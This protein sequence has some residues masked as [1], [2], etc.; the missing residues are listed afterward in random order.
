SD[1]SDDCVAGSLVGSASASV[2]GANG[3]DYI[4]SPALSV[5]A[6][7]TYHWT[8]SYAGD[9]N[10]SSSASACGALNENPVVNPRPTTLTTNAGGP[11]TI[12]ADGT[13]SLTDTATLSGGTSNATGTIS[14]KL[15][16]PDPTP[17]S[18][19]SDDCV[20]G[21]LVGS[22]SAS[23]SG[24]NGKDYISSPAL[25]V[26]AAGTYHWTASYDGDT[27]NSSSASACGAL[28][29]NPVVNPRPTTLTTNAGGPFTIGADG[30]VSL[31]DT[32][33]LSGGTSN[34]TGTI[35]FK[36]YGPDPTPGSDPSDDCVVGSLVGF[37]PAR[38]LGA[39]RPDLKHLPA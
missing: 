3:K 5:S 2:S 26:S 11:F 29:E 39:I 16:G 20:A 7:G 27:N 12:G 24:A 9:T 38:F 35:S 31:T 6:A 8:A 34:A 37:A 33:T 25:S 17:G 30:T 32:A 19:P 14:F 36:L 22:A 15:Y 13:V 10:N 21:S 4:S 18:D 28:N 23:V 1:P